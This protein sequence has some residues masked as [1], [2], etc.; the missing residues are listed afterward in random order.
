MAAFNDLIVDQP[1]QRHRGRV[2]ARQDPRDRARPGGRRTAGA[3]EPSDRHQADLRRHRLLRDLQPRRT[4]RWSMCG[5]TPISE[6]TPHGVRAGDAEYELDAIVFATGFDA[7]TGALLKHRHPRRDGADAAARSGRRGRAPISGLM[8]AG[9]PNLFMITGPGSPSV[10][11]NMMVSIEQHVD[12]IADCVGV[13]ARA[14]RST[15]S[16]R[17]RRPRTRGSTHVQRGGRHRRCTRWPTPGTWAPT[18]PASRGVH[19]V[20]RRRRR[21]S[22]HLRRDRGGGLSRVRSDGAGCRVGGGVAGPGT[23]VTPCRG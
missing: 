7:M 22:A 17:R 10:L 5:A 15:A 11:S 1:G 19:A 3:E 12:W 4:S 21:V 13:S 18:S 16:R 6:I 9:F 2:R 8:T 23:P 14:R 20:Y